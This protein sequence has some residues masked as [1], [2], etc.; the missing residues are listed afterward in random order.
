MLAPC[1]VAVPDGSPASKPSSSFVLH[2]MRDTAMQAWAC[3]HTVRWLFLTAVPFKL[4]NDGAQ[5]VGPFFLN[6]LLDVIQTGNAQ[7]PVFFK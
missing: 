4:L 7:V 3:W 6:K 5:F 1:A 2:V